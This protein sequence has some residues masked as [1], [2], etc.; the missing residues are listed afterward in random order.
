MERK[1]LWQGLWIIVLG[2]F[3]LVLTFVLHGLGYVKSDRLILFYGPSAALVVLGVVV[4]VLSQRI[5]RRAS[6]K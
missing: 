6:V 2:V 1:T 3:F 5:P 4:L